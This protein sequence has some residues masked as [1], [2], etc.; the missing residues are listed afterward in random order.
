MNSWL[1]YG[2][3]RAG[4]CDLIAIDVV[5][6][7]L[8]LHRHKFVHQRAVAIT[9]HIFVQALGATPSTGP[10]VR[11]QALVFLERLHQPH[12]VCS[13]I[14]ASEVHEGIAEVALTAEVHGHVDEVEQ[15]TVTCL[16]EALH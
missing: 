6:R 2:L 3:C 10:L 7:W 4:E 1:G 15:A 12:D 13:H 8:A 14:V 5:Q 9:F 11:L 16:N